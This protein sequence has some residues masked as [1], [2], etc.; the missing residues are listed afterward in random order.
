M[1]VFMS[2]LEHHE[3]QHIQIMKE[4]KTNQGFAM[5]TPNYGFR[6]SFKG[7]SRI[8]IIQSRLIMDIQILDQ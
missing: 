3:Q 1:H 2:L 4:N 5:G 8:Y 7:E 6:E